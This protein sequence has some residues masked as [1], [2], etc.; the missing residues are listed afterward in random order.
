MPLLV[1][2]AICTALGCIFFF[3][4]PWLLPAVPVCNSLRLQGAPANALI[5][6]VQVR[7]SSELRLQ[8]RNAPRHKLLLVQP[9]LVCRCAGVEQEPGSK[10]LRYRW[11]GRSVSTD[12]CWL[13]DGLHHNC[14]PTCSSIPATLVFSLKS[15]HLVL[16]H[17]L[18]LSF[19]CKNICSFLSFDAN[20]E[21]SKHIHTYLHSREENPRDP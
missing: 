17:F 6:Y 1:G 10:A 9:K 21:T 11:L 8:P 3:L 16:L 2:L 13:L 4:L 19:C 15:P 5:R 18:S 20:R 7:M 12:R 14:F